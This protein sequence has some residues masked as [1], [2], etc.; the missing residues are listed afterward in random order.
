[1]NIF[2]KAGKQEMKLNEVALLMS[3]LRLPISFVFT[4][5]NLEEE[6]EKFLNSDVYEPIFKYRLVKNNNEDILKRLSSLK[7][8]TDVDPRISDFY[9]QLIDIDH[10]GHWLKRNHIH[11]L[12]N[13]KRADDTGNRC[14]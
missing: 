8:I 12:F 13:L 6:K 7:V 3:K 4:P 9:I 11:A 5:V 1:M 2:S 14:I 10:F